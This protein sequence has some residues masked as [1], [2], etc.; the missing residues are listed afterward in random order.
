MKRRFRDFVKPRF[1]F[2]SMEPYD[3]DLKSVG[4][5]LKSALVAAK[6]KQKTLAGHFG[7]TEQAVSQWFRNETSFDKGKLFELANMLKVRPEWILDGTLPR[8]VPTVPE[9]FELTVPD[10]NIQQWP[11]DVPILG[12]ASCGDDG[13]F[14]LNGQTLD[15][16][17]RPPRLSGA[18]G[19]YALFVHGESMSPW[20]EPGELVYVHPHQPVKIGD[21]VVVQMVPEPG[22]PSAAY[23]KRLVRRTA[24]KLVLMQFNPRE[25]KTLP[26][27]KVKAIHRIMSWS[28]L[29]GI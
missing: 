7:V 11:F 5:R 13:L 21:Y 15:Y 2:P 22:K 19:V 12:G 14:E 16:A 1:S 24:D 6:M 27:K 29:M 23:I 3:D 25:E 9:N 18:K 4:G 17:R 26:M 8:E 20:R 28:E 10:L